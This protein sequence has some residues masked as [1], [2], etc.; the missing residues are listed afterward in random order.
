MPGVSPAKQRTPQ[1][2]PA[3]RVRRRIIGA[4]AAVLALAALLLLLGRERPLPVQQDAGGR[5]ALEEQAAPK[6]PVHET[7]TK[8]TSPI[9]KPAAPLQP[10]D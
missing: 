4:V 5:P 8:D 1:T 10:P 2:S 7:R 9:G 6:P 3:R